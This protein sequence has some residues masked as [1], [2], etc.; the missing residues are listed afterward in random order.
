LRRR[1]PAVLLDRDGVINRRRPEHVR[2][3]DQFEFMPGCLA[4]LRL[5][6]ARRARVLVVTNQSV[7][8]RGLIAEA[9]L[10]QIHHRMCEAVERA[11][12]LIEAVLACV[13]APT[14]GCGCRKPAPGLFLRA[15]S[16]LLVDLGRSVMIGDSRSD[17]EAALAGGC[18][19]V[20]I[21]PDRGPAAAPARTAGDLLEAVT[22][23]GAC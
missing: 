19:A 5:L 8:G 14:D 13:H 3:W 22:L 15:E 12:G 4:A 20:W 2:S 17:V 7:V 10:R 21:G 1:S 9:Q 18:G 16:E 6:R 11:G 23:L